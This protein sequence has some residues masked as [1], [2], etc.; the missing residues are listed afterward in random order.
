MAAASSKLNNRLTE[1]P[2]AWNVFFVSILSVGALITIVPVALIVIVSFSSKESVAELGYTFFPMS[3]SLEGYDYL[4]KLGDQLARSY[5]VTIQYAVLGTILSVLT[6]SLYAYVLAQPKFPLRKFLTWFMFF[7]M[8]FN[9]GL[10]TNYILRTRYLNMQDTFWVLLLNGLADGFSIIILRTF[11]KSAVPD[12]II[13]SAR[14]D[15]AGHFRTYMTI[16]MPLLKAGLATIGLFG[17]VMRWNDWFTAFLYN[18]KPAL[19][20]LQ[21][22]L[23]RMLRQIEFFINN[24]ELMGTMD[25]LEMLKTLPGVNLRMACT[26]IVIMPIIFAYP[27]FQQF[28]VKGMLVGSIKE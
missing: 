20:P 16:V 3:W 25:A 23:Y 12:S 10:V 28:F 5:I 9:G 22:M 18:S 2:A 19:I 11:M 13:E 15:G 8:L 24:S 27:F 1:I 26:V 7:T 4:F 17:F 14:I 21:T 6:M